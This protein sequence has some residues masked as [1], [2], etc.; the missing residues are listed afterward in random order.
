MNKLL[1]TTSLL[2]GLLIATA[3]PVSTAWSYTSADCRR[4]VCEP[5]ICHCFGIN[6]FWCIQLRK[7]FCT[8]HLFCRGPF[9]ACSCILVSPRPAQG[10]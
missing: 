10:G 1:Q 5:G 8:G 4:L 7:A 3:S 6:S 2:L 9:C